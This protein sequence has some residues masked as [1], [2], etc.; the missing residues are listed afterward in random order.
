LLPLV[1][2]YAD[3][4]FENPRS[5]ADSCYGEHIIRY[6]SVEILAVG[7]LRAPPASLC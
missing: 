3:I 1:C 6:K 2:L 5:D 4:I 7:G